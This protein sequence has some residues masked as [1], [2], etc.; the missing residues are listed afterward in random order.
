MCV[1]VCVC[2]S[3]HMSCVQAASVL[4]P[5]VATLATPTTSTSQP[6]QQPASA[7]TKPY[8]ALP[9]RP[10]LSPNCNSQNPFDLITPQVG[11]STTP[12]E[13]TAILPSEP[14]L[15]APGWALPV[16]SVD[17]LDCREQTGVNFSAT[18]VSNSGVSAGVNANDSGLLHSAGNI[19]APAQSGG[20]PPATVWLLGEV[21]GHESIPPPSIM[22]AAASIN[23]SGFAALPHTAPLR[24]FRSAVFDSEQAFTRALVQLPKL[25]ATRLDALHPAGSVGSGLRNERGFG[26]GSDGGSGGVYGGGF[27]SRVPP[28]KRSEK[29]VML[30]AARVA[31]GIMQVNTS[32]CLCVCLFVCLFVCFVL[33]VCLFVCLFCFVLFCFIFLFYF[34]CVFILLLLLFIFIVYILFSIVSTLSN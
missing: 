9:D 33:F 19:S 21:D 27:V 11:K 29:V 18:C 5:A 25:L 3:V 7:L 15:S 12:A 22:A 14:L 13:F 4:P 31:L 8:P 2:V 28:L 16:S 1:C 20:S 23:D 34:L 32:V 26:V 30:T 10:T 6:L 24:S 17:K